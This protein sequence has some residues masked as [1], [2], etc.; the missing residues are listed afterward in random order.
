MTIAEFVRIYPLRTPNIMWLFGAGASASAG[1]PTAEHMTWEFKRAIYCTEQHV[2]VAS[3][4]DLGDTILRMRIQRYLDSTRRFPPAGSPEEYAAYFEAAYP[5]EADR[6]RHVDRMVSAASPSYG[7]LVL[8]A[9]LA[10]DRVRLIWTPNFD[11]MIEDAVLPLLGSSGRLAVATL[12]NAELAEHAM[13][14]GRWPLLVKL[15]GDF[16]SRRL[17]NTSEELRAQDAKLRQALVE[18]CKRFGLAVV[19]YSG[20]DGS[21]MDALEEGIHGGRGYPLGLFWFHRPETPPLPRVTQLIELASASG[22]EASLIEAETFDEVMGDTL[23]L[24]PDIPAALKEHVD[25]RARRVS[26]APLPAPQGGWPVIRLNAL[27]LLSWPSVCRRVV[28][29]IGGA[30]EV[31]QAIADAQT[32]LV[33]ARRDVGVIAFGSD[34]EIRRTFER[35]N[36]TNF[37]IHS[38]E[39]ARLQR[40]T[41]ELGLLYDALCRALSRERPLVWFR[42]REHVLIVDVQREHDGVFGNLRAAAGAISGVVPGTSLRWVE[43]IRIRLEYKLER[44]WL[45]IVPFVWVERS[46]DND[47]LAV[48]REFVR[49]RRAARF[50]RQW[51]QILEA[52]VSIITS[53]ESATEVR[54]FGISDGIDAVFSI[55]STTGFSRRGSQS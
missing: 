50:N 33:A 8:A 29:E 51:N 25:V 55:G 10:L 47:A 2:S 39:P 4:S 17:K 7:H 23:L 3:A 28:C 27:P 46:A 54:A 35:H 21:I 31:R 30:R 48:S 41:A 49:E 15:H 18:G 12:D 6:R 5:S 32:D 40:D 34:V 37:D 42:G 1:V 38:I 26:E 16:Q 20:R 13:N 43:G 45:L 53:G 9:L 44:P 52:W 22:T 36:V 19:G 14:E 11:R 24:I